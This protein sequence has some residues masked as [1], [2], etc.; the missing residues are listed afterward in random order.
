[1]KF[2]SNDAVTIKTH[3]VELIWC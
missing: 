2:L 3:I 1:M